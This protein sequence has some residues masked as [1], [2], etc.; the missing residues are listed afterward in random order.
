MPVYKVAGRVTDRWYGVHCKNNVADLYDRQCQQQGCRHTLSVALCEEAVS[1]IAVCDGDEAP[2]IPA[3][4]NGLLLNQAEVTGAE[5]V[6]AGSMWPKHVLMY[7]MSANIDVLS[8]KV[9]HS[10]KFM[11]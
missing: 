3:S 1:I 8:A 7:V 11:F 4:V 9:Q 6:M 10:L 2:A 5:G